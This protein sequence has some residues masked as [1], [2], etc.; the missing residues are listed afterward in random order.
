MHRV[1]GYRDVAG[2]EQS[3]QRGKNL[4]RQALLHLRTLGKELHDAVNFRQADYRIFRDISNGRFAVNRH[5]VMFTGTGQRD[6]ADRHHLVNFHFVFN[7]GDFRESGV[8]QTGENLINVHFCD[9]M[10][11]FHQAVVTEIKIQQLHN[12]SH[13]PGDQTLARFIINFLYWRTQRR[14]QPT[15]DQRFMNEY[16]FFTQ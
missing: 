4:L 9:A 5:K 14:L 8:I 15:S 16:G 6:I 3:L 1:N 11:S 12:L 10:R 2:T 7:N 13:V